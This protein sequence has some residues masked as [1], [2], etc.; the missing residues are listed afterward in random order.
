[1]RIIS[2]F[3][4]YYDCIQGYG[5]DDL[6]YIRHPIETKE[7]YLGLRQQITSIPKYHWKN[8]RI[9]FCGKLYSGYKF[10]QGLNSTKFMYNPEEVEGF[11]NE[12]DIRYKSKNKWDSG[13]GSDY[14]HLEKANATN[15]YLPICEKYLTP[16][17]VVESSIYSQVIQGKKIINRWTELATINARLNQ[18]DFQKVFGPVEAFMAIQTFISN[19]AYPNKP[20]PHVSD[21]DLVSAKGFDKFSFRKDKKI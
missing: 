21:E 12:N 6:K 10:T 17:V 7:I 16:I 1:M 9:L 5:Q 18:Y 11:C 20:I 15:N 3:K 4:D 8:V 19:L 14:E 2:N 13:F